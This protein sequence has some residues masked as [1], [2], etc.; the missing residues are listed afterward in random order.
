MKTTK[1]KLPNKNRPT[2]HE[3]NINQSYLPVIAATIV[4]SR[5]MIVSIIILSSLVMC[6]TDMNLRSARDTV[7]NTTLNFPGISGSAGAAWGRF[8]A[9]P[10]QHVVST[11]VASFGTVLMIVCHTAP[12]PK[13][14]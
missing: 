14:T 3:G 8:G 12:P 1:N 6:G 9:P 11:H 4:S 5:V 13:F 7:L 2:N 10:K